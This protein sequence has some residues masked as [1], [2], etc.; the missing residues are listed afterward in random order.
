MVRRLAEFI[1][2]IAIIKGFAREQ[3]V[4]D[5]FA[6]ANRAVRE[7]QEA[8]FWHESLFGPGIAFLTQINIFIVLLYGGH[9]VIRGELPLGLGLVVFVGLV[10]Q[11]SG[12]VQNLANI[13]NIAM[14]SLT[15]AERV[16]EI[17]DAPVA[18]R[19]PS[20][21][22]NL[23]PPRNGR[24]ICFENVSFHHHAEE[25]ALAEISFEARPGQCVAI[26]GATGAGKST[27]LSL[28]PRFYDPTSGRVLMDGIDLRQLDLDELRRN[29]GL[30]FQESFLFSN[31]IAANIA[32]G[33]PTASREQIERA[34]RIAAAHDF[35]LDMP[36]GY[37]T[38]LRETGSNLSG[39]QRQRL[40][41]ARALLLDPPI[42]LLDDPTAA[43]DPQ[44][45]HEILTAMES[46][47]AG[48]TTFIVSH[49]LSA[50][51]RANLIVVLDEG[52]I[53]QIGTHQDLIR[54]DGHYRRT[55]ELQFSAG[56]LVTP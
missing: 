56:L 17:L 51:R 47:T 36:R 22:V 42:L 43:V 45:E 16:F 7:Q 26:L 50:V 37:D 44:T 4:S 54:V 32:F 20:K 19:S 28:I 3:Q 49:R 11:F 53:A 2:G 34:A 31:T 48:R 29:I 14:Q 21:P 55:A 46:A 27:L 52:R 24:A 12:Q 38:V 6:S 35:I 39:G 30:V 1:Q 18:I 40:A 10:Q 15:G 9:L 8:I 13:N 25:V 33:H 5:E 23:P 41:L